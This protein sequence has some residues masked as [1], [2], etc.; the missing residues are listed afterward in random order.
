MGV[1]GQGEGVRRWGEEYGG[2]ERRHVDVNSFGLEVDRP[3]SQAFKY[4]AAITS[5]GL[6]YENVSINSRTD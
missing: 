3:S 1:G 2:V 5:F 6:D 4:S